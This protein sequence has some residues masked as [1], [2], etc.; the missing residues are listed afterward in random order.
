MKNKWKKTFVIRVE[1][2]GCHV[3]SDVAHKFSSSI[4]DVEKLHQVKEVVVHHDAYQ[5]ERLWKH[6]KLPYFIH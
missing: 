5:M 4:I 1:I 6:Q 3:E 2:F